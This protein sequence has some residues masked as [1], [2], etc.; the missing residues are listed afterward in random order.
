MN[1][2][3]LL[4]HRGMQKRFTN[5]AQYTGRQSNRQADRSN[6]ERATTGFGVGQI[7]VWYTGNQLKDQADTSSREKAKAGFV[8]QAE[9]INTRKSIHKGKLLGR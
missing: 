7:E 8:K 6:K 2:V 5:R 9:V 3:A 1:S 4:G